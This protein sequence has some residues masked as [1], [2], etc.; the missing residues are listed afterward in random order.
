MGLNRLP[1]NEFENDVQ[2]LVTHALAEAFKVQRKRGDGV[3]RAVTGKGRVVRPWH[4]D[5]S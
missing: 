5:R 4:L 3:D 2:K 1:R